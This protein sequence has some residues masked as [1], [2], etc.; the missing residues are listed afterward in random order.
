MSRFNANECLPVFEGVSH[1]FN[2]EEDEFVEIEEDNNNVNNNNNY[3]NNNNI[4]NNTIYQQNNNNKTKPYEN[5]IQKNEVAFNLQHD[6]PKSN[7]KIDDLFDLLDDTTN[8]KEPVNMTEQQ[9]PFT[10][11]INHTFTQPLDHHNSNNFHPTITINSTSMNT[12]QNIMDVGATFHLSN[13]IDLTGR[14]QTTDLN[15]GQEDEFIEIEEEND[16]VKFDNGVKGQNNLNNSHIEPP[17]ATKTTD[18]TPKEINF[19]ELLF[20][21]PIITRPTQQEEPKSESTKNLPQVDSKKEIPDKF[22]S[23]LSLDDL[24]IDMD[25]GNKKVETKNPEHQQNM[26]NLLNNDFQN[27]NEIINT[28]NLEN[29]IENN[30]DDLEFCEVEENEQ[31]KEAEQLTFNNPTQSE[32]IAQPNVKEEIDYMKCKRL[33]NL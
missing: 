18:D 6:V 33:Y 19:Q 8:N 23:L 12:Q 28:A 11:S 7:K 29:K 20:S 32:P 5:P 25:I 13:G 2:Y 31:P 16:E 10:Q 26:N 21:Q 24:L 4:F 22:Q 27:N 1:Q 14:Q 3:N 15:N 9:L 30:V 17:G